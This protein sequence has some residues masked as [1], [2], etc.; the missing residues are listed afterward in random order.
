MIGSRN[1]TVFAFVDN[2]LPPRTDPD[3]DKLGKIRPV[4]DSVTQQFLTVYNPHCEVSI[5]EAMIAF[6]GRSSMKQYMPKKPVKRGFKVW[7]RPDAVSGYVSEIDVY[8][9]KGGP[10]REYG[11]GSNVGW[12]LTRNITG[13]H[14]AVYCDNFFTSATLFKDLLQDEVYACGTYN[15]TRKC[16]P[17][18]LKPLAKSERGIPL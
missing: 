1:I 15:H 7:V 3:Y 11:L 4:L 13:H 5:D 10:W 16:Y 12:R 18:D 17:K 2:T 8:T 6:K 9:G 14:H